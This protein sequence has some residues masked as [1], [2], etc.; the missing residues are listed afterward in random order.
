MNLKFS[1]IA[2]AGDLLK[3]RLVLK[4]GGPVALGDYLVMLSTVNSEGSP[5]AGSHTIYWFPDGNVKSGDQV[6][7]YT[8]AGTSSKKALE[9]GATAHFFYWG[10]G[11]PVWRASEGNRAI[12]LR[13]AEWELAKTVKRV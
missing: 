11:A 9:Q 4:A 12:I 1:S 2:D 5:Y 7:L 8:K 10:L 13:S 3:E 6:I